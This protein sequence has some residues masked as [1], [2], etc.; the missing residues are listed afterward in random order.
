MTA[1]TSGAGW[2]AGSGQSST[3]ETAKQVAGT[4]ADETRHVADVAG[5]EAQNVGQEAKERAKDLMTHLRSQAQEQSSTQKDRLVDTLRQFSDELQQMADSSGSSG[6]ANDVVRQVSSKARD[7]YQ[8]M[9]HREPGDL[10]DEVRRFARRRPGTFLLGAAAAGVLAG[11]LT[12][13]AKSSTSGGGG[14]GE[15]YGTASMPVTATPQVTPPRTTPPP[16][17]GTGYPTTYPP[18]ST[19][20]G[21]GP[22]AIDPVEPGMPPRPYPQTGGGTS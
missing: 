11:R 16:P 7:L 3:T 22:G 19:S 2:S 17:A 20:P 8:N 21:V 6:L 12:R 5:Q 10:L 13:G 9:E 18:A 1:Q 15:G 14:E 4:A